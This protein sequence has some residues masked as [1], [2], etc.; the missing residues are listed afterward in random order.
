L[1]NASVAGEM[2]EASAGFSFLESSIV[3]LQLR[4]PIP[5]SKAMMSVI[6]EAQSPSQAGEEYVFRKDLFKI[7][8]DTREQSQRKSVTLEDWLH[9]F[10][11]SCTF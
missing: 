10:N 1:T 11:F 9:V 3:S 8:R 2:W 5:D 6:D 4:K 7:T